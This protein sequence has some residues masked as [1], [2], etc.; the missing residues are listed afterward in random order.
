M[1]A[2]ILEGHDQALRVLEQAAALSGSF[3]TGCGRKPCLALVT[4]ETQASAL[5]YI[6]RIEAYAASSEVSV[7]TVELP[8]D[9]TTEQAVAAIGKLSTDDGI[10]GILPLAPFPPHIPF[11]QIAAAISPDKD[12]DGLTAFNA[13][14]LARGLDGLFPCTPQAAIRLAEAAAGPL[15]GMTAT[16]VGASGHVGRPL[17][18][19]LLQRG[20]TV[21][22]AHLDTQDLSAACL[23]SQLLFVAVGKAGLITNRHVSP[24]AVVIDIGINA[25]DD[26]KGGTMIVGDADR[27]TV[28]PIAAALSAA[29]DGVGPLTSA[30]LI[31]NCVT[32]ATRRLSV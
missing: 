10:D 22:I 9:A 14:Q 29:P 18:E 12:V 21:T 31:E 4:A 19:M 28:A 27:G 15:R 11:A 7:V 1:T 23:P 13:G 6:R 32:A 5:A 26:G 3:Q 16:V 2:I 8:V 30:F 24:G 17:T 20:V 25:I